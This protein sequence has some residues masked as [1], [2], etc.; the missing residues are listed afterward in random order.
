MRPQLSENAKNEI[1][2]Y[3]EKLIISKKYLHSEATS[4]L[5]MMLRSC[6]F[7]YVTEGGSVVHSRRTCGNVYNCM[8]PV[9]MAVRFGYKKPC[10]TCGRGS[11]VE[12]LLAERVNS[13][14]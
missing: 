8:L 2:D 13:I 7:V 10:S 11:Y 1:H 12:Q 14:E 3:F 9:D 4:T 5:E 6:G